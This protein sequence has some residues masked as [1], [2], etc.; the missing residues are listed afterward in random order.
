M[1]TIERL[2]NNN[3]LLK[4]TWTGFFFC[5]RACPFSQGTL[6]NPKISLFFG[7]YLISK[8]LNHFFPFWLNWNFHIFEIC[9]LF[10]SVQLSFLEPHS[11][12]HDIV[13]PGTCTAGAY[14]HAKSLLVAS[15]SLQSHVLQPARLLSPW[16]SPGKNTG[17]GC[18]FLLQGIFLIQGSHPHRLSL[19]HWQ[20]GSSPLAPPG[21]PI[22][23]SVP[24][25]DSE[26]HWAD[27]RVPLCALSP[28]K[29]PDTQNFI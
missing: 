27:F 28:S 15:N 10:I 9:D 16:N 11:A 23:S 20:A 14:Q 3:A 4:Q 18:H 7:L 5:P 24:A 13:L 8:L 21:K 1:D 2:N 12:M 25:K 17:V 22:H 29:Y 26:D 19:L 6:L